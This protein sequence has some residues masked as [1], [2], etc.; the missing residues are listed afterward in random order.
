MVLDLTSGRLSDAIAHATSALE[1]VEARLIE[2]RNGSSGQLPPLPEEPATD[3]KGK[4]K[5][6]ARLVRDD[7][8]QKMSSQ[9]I[10]AEIRELS[11]LKD[12]LA[13]KVSKEPQSA[14]FF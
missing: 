1:S 11:G 10:E 3:S 13:L 7:A 9:R 14:V 12:D 2:L 5:A 8:V 4:G 6:V